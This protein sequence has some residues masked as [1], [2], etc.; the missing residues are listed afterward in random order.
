MRFWSVRN[1]D[2]RL[3]RFLIT[4]ILKRNRHEA[5]NRMLFDGGTNPAFIFAPFSFTLLNKVYNWSAPKKT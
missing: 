1:L 5:I 3:V 2:L 4:K